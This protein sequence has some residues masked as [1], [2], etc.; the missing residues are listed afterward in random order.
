MTHLNQGS[1]PRV[2][3][4]RL[5]YKH[6]FIYI[7]KDVSDNAKTPRILQCDEPLNSGALPPFVNALHNMIHIKNDTAEKYVDCWIEQLQDPQNHICQHKN[8]SCVIVLARNF[9]LLTCLDVK[10]YNFTAPKLGPHFLHTKYP[11]VQLNGQNLFQSLT[12]CKDQSEH[13]TCRLLTVNAFQ[14]AIL[15]DLSC[16]CNGENCVDVILDQASNGP[17]MR[18]QIDLSVSH[19]SKPIFMNIGYANKVRSDSNYDWVVWIMPIPFLLVI[20]GLAI[21]FFYTECS[22]EK[23]RSDFTL[24]LYHEGHTTPLEEVI[25]ELANKE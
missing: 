2:I 5:N 16:C 1:V 14:H 18:I 3:E 15:E 9:T 13:K 22:I 20:L 24:N 6:D 8:S 19:A 17:I 12:D 25:I 4:P 11:I 10:T 7:K 23:Q 21:Y